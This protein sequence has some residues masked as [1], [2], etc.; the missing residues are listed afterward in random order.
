VQV[1][2]GSSAPAG[3]A[4]RLSADVFRSTLARKKAAIEA[5]GRNA[6]AGDPSLRG[7]LTFLIT[8]DTAGAVAAEVEA[9]A[10]SSGMQAVAACV[11]GKLR[12]MNFSSSPPQG[13]DFRVRLPLQL[14]AS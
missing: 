12:T 2:L 6:A 7:E 8:I 4:G 1:Q 14:G 13:G 3:G 9:G 11:I 10:S 5:C